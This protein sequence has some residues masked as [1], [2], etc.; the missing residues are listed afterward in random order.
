MLIRSNLA[1]AA[2]MLAALAGIVASQ[3]RRL[4]MQLATAHG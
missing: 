3:E 4:R 1:I 2:T